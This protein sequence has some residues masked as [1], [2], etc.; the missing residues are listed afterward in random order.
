[1]QP[2]G[3]DIHLTTRIFGHEKERWEH[4][5]VKNLQTINYD[6][7]ERIKKYAVKQTTS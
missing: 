6:N 7:D 4:A 1:L 2:A 5:Q 3:F